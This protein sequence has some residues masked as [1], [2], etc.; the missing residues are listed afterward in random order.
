M[1]ATDAEMTQATQ[2][3]EG[4][5]HLPDGQRLMILKMEL[6][7]FKSY[8]NTVTI[9]P[10]DKNMTSVVGPNGS[11]KS[12][13]IDAM[14]FVF[15]FNA[16]KMR[17]DKVSS[18]I[19]SSAEYPDCQFAKVAVHFA[20]IIDQPD[21][22]YTIVEGSELVVSREARKD[23]SSSYRV[24]EKVKQYKEVAA[25]LRTRGIDLDHNRFLILQGE[26]EQISMMK[27]KAASPHEDGL[28][29]YLEDIIGSNKLVPLIEESFKSMEELNEARAS[30]L[31]ALKAAEANVSALEGRKAE[32]ES[33]LAAEAQ[34][35]T[36][37]SAL[38]Q[39]HAA[40]SSAAAEKA[41]AEHAE[42]KETMAAELEKGAGLIAECGEMEKAYKKDKK[43]YDK[44]AE[45]LE[46]SRKEFQKF[47]REDIKYGE[48]VKADKAA[49]NKA[50]AAT[51]REERKLGEAR[52][53]LAA[54]TEDIP[55]LEKEAAELG[56][57]QA[58]ASSEL[59]GMYDGLKE[60]ADPLR[61]KMDDIEKAR[62]PDAEALDGVK[63]ELGLLESEKSL[64]DKKLADAAAEKDAAAAELAAHAEA[65]A[66]SRDEA[67]AAEAE[68]AETA[69]KVGAAQEAVA[70]A[71]EQE[72]GL[73]DAEKAA[74][75][76]YEEAKAAKESA[77]TAS[78]NK[79]LK[80]LLAAKKAGAIPGVLGRLGS[81]GKVAPQYDVAASTAC[82][83]LDHIVVDTRAT[84]EAC[85]TL[86]REK[87]LGVATFIILDK[88]AELLGGVMAKKFAAPAGARRLFDLIEVAEPSHAPAFYSAFRDTL[89][90]D[91]KEKAKAI[92]FN[93]AV[94]HRV[95][96]LDGVVINTSG[97][98]EG[99]GEPRKG[100][101]GPSAADAA[102]DGGISDAEIE[103]LLQGATAASQQ[104]DGVRARSAEAREALRNLQR[105]QGKRATHLKKLRMQIEAADA[106]KAALEARVSRAAS[107]SGLS[108]EEAGRMG[109]LDKEMA[110]VGKRIADAKAKVDKADEKLAK[111]QEE[112]LA[113]GGVR[114]RAQKS[115]V[116]TLGEQ[117]KGVEGRLSKARA[118]S[119]G[120]E[121]G[122]AKLEAAV[123][124][125][126]EAAEA[127]E[128]KIKAT[129]A[130]KAALEEEALEVMRTYEACQAELAEKEEGLQAT[131]AKYEKAK[132]K[133]GSI[134]KEEARMEG[135]LDELSAASADADKKAQGWL[136]K[137]QQLRDSIE[138]SAEEAKKDAAAAA[139]EGGADAAAEG[140]EV[141]AAVSA[142]AAAAEE[143]LR[144]L[145]AEELDAL[146]VAGLEKEVGKLGDALGAMDGNLG[147]LAE[148]KVRE[149]ERKARLAEF[150]LVT[151]ER[152]GKR[153]SYEV[154][155][156]QRLD[157]FMVGFRIIGTKLKEM[158]Q[159][160]TLGGD[161]ELELL[162]SLDP[163]SE[164][165]VFSVR[166]PK[167]SWK[168]IGNLS[169]GEKT[170]SSLALVF[171][172]HHY[173]PTPLY[174]MDEIDAALDFRNVS[175]VGNYIK[176][177]TRNAQFI[178]ISLRNN[179]F[180][181]ADRLVGIYKTQNATKSVAINPAA[182]TVA[183]R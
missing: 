90:C 43:D 51:E 179:M 71:A 110:K 74:R 109:E 161:A 27:P 65:T 84:A 63:A 154:L 2:P 8:A 164:G 114:L 26:V 72:K 92:A 88:Q 108:K 85:V 121:K 78:N 35:R 53:E 174:V 140:E 30:K 68:E 180:E 158:Y 146:D 151:A 177:R 80:G 82:G 129:K 25:L 105:D 93:G 14:L 167:K 144:D 32:A 136:A 81:L 159:M 157:E 75:A 44:L 5:T 182:F 133:V 160:I 147:A 17:Q 97:T 98:M 42:L 29:E 119:E 39:K 111:L 176:E 15:G 87:A 106:T 48:E 60:Q 89:V 178:I 134:R 58:Q 156:K 6:T 36:K 170:L 41:R 49:R 95:V 40:A 172:L 166:P 148:Y 132:G 64:L 1:A 19:H 116:E 62:A 112:V 113:L 168:Q 20:N 22:S 142:S 150:D 118:Q 52:A 9:G 83:A 86:L 12:N 94:R 46:A 7:N 183:A 4:A 117:L 3:V 123:A 141:D 23:N 169:G 77:S 57:S 10:F 122:V 18:L 101:I 135:M 103:R 69:A 126:K 173:K 107:A 33:Y 145:S 28:L 66:R 124:S 50:R 13:V 99:G 137:L 131:K 59:E 24:D 21:G 31:N 61:K 34:L 149:R 96:T 70:Q 67:K 38:F 143:A 100:R 162:D 16:K 37:R 175:I 104:L 130:K 163:F 45:Q 54:L 11:G 55:R 152:D 125:A 73:V 120:S 91:D 127:L 165:I 56:A 102:A 171:A 155:R 128:E 138:E 76:K 79:A 139:A 153:K 47:E 181:L 115:K